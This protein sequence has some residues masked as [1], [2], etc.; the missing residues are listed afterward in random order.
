VPLLKKEETNVTPGSED[1]DAYTASGRMY[2]LNAIF[3]G[4]TTTSGNSVSL[5]SLG[6]VIVERNGTQIFNVPARTLLQMVDEQK[7]TIEVTTPSGGA[8]RVV[9]PIPFWY[10]ERDPNALNVRNDEELR[11]E[12][13]PDQ[14]QL[15][16]DFDSG[17]NLKL[18]SIRAPNTQEQYV[19]RILQSRLS[20]NGSGETD[21][22]ELNAAGLV[23]LFF[24]ETAADVVGSQGLQVEWDG[25]VAVESLDP[26]VLND[27]ANQLNRVESS[28]DDLFEFNPLSGPGAQ[29]ASDSGA[30][31]TVNSGGA[32]D[33]IITRVLQT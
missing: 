8:T 21:S 12:I 22:E 20:F 16:T 6:R 15:S 17:G 24:R 3:T 18:V 9:V 27:V 7:G 23:R 32:G 4:G 19:P 11:V 14:S 26:E 5:E 2:Q 13:Q 25:R 29:G 10:P 28:P 1:L 30:K 31:V 33:L